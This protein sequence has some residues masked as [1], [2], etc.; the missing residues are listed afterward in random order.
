M[1][2]P[3]GRHS[4]DAF[5][6]GLAGGEV[7]DQTRELVA[8]AEHLCVAAAA[9]P[10]DEFVTDLRSHL[11]AEAADVLVVA[12]PRSAVSA[13]RISRSRRRLATVATAAIVATGGVG[14][15][16]SSASA[17]PGQMLYPIKQG[18]ESVE[19]ATKPD[20]ASKARFELHRAS[21]RLDEAS[22]L[23]TRGDN[24]Q[25][26][27]LI[28]HALEDF[29][30]QASTGSQSLTADSL[31]SQSTLTLSSFTVQSQEKLADLAGTVPASSRPALMAATAFVDQLRQDL[32]AVCVSCDRDD[33][34]SLGA[35]TDEAAKQ[36]K[37]PPRATDAPAQQQAAAPVVK[38][39]DKTSP[40]VATASPPSAGPSTAPSAVSPPKTVVDVVK[41]ITGLLLGDEDQTGL[42]PGLL[43]VTGLNSK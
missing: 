28:T 8:F 11:M 9:E 10:P 19:L 37:S 15:V 33:L 29:E 22:Q 40:P 3:W 27:A 35:A 43:G 39:P 2:G 21:E 25:D 32:L 1:T 24:G 5:A 20:D 42:I 12:R 18:V 17:L 7:D 13:A 36:L 41:P 4:A 23:A 16:T 31:S 26:A 14:L 34:E 38:A 6:A 30:Q